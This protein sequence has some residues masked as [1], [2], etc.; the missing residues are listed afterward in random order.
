[1]AL[2]RSR[3]LDFCACKATL[4]MDTGSFLRQPHLHQRFDA[5]IFIAPARGL[6]NTIRAEARKL[7]SPTN[8]NTTT[9]RLAWSAVVSGGPAIRESLRP[10]KMFCCTSIHPASPKTLLSA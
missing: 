5:N 10:P 3:A 6:L 2:Q 7:D 8:T 4:P 1:M 9:Y